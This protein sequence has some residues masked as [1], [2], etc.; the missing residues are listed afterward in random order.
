MNSIMPTQPAIQVKD[1]MAHYRSRLHQIGDWKVIGSAATVPIRLSW[2]TT[3][4]E[5]CVRTEELTVIAA[6]LDLDYSELGRHKARVI[7]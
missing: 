1:E 4:T 7:H 5:L 3:A 6:T 2:P